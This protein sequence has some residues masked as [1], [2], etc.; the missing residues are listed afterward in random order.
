MV[1]RYI[2]KALIL[3]L[4]IQSA[5]VWAEWCVENVRAI[6]TTED[7]W[8]MAPKWSPN[9]KKIA[10]TG[11]KW[12][13][14]YL[15][16]A[17][18]WG[19]IEILTENDSGHWITW[20]SDSKAIFFRNRNQIKIVKIENKETKSVITMREGSSFP[21]RLS[22]GKWFYTAREKS[23]VEAEKD[24]FTLIFCNSKG[25]IEKEIET[26][27][28]GGG[29]IS[30]DGKKIVYSEPFVSGKLVTFDTVC[31]WLT[32]DDGTNKE[33]LL[34]GQ[35]LLVEWSPDSKKILIS[36]DGGH[37][38]C[39]F[40]IETKTVFDLGRGSNG[41]WS[42]DGVWILYTVTESDGHRLTASDIYLIKWDGTE[43]SRL[44]ETED[45]IEVKPCFSPD[46][47]KIAFSVE[48]GRIFVADL[49]NKEE[50]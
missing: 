37:S 36:S 17:D 45:L 27:I 50:K 10:F 2:V 38:Q 43:K 7:G 14:I 12:R 31:V 15:K 25:E 39:V 34:K 32:D 47:K 35:Y 42:P 20:S 23:E 44:T 1:S 26:D 21:C 19:A 5:R 48:D 3:F 13:G 29:M 18:R 41:C 49:I 22:T 16:N 24:K 9:G 33:L 6:T 4:G 46:G 30:P 11:A 28:W 40:E 8:F